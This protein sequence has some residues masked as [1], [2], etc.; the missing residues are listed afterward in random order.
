MKRSWNIEVPEG[1]R[2]KLDVLFLNLEDDT[3]CSKDS[4]T[5]KNTFLSRKFL[6]Y[7]GR[8]L[9][10]SYLSKRNVV[11]VVFQSDEFNVGTGFKIRY[12]AVLGK[13]FLFKQLYSVFLI[14]VNNWKTTFFYYR[15]K[16]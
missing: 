16:H 11:Y 15:P 12:E 8:T 3:L 5:I 4:I 1:Q 9:P 7:C 10:T 2:I 14:V 6:S 13:C